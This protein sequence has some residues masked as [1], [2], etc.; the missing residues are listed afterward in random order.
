MTSATTTTGAAPLCFILM[1]FGKKTGADGTTIDF[2]RVYG[3][4]IAPAAA[5][6][7]LQPIRADEET[8]GGI[9]HKAMF[10]RLILCP[11][12][13]ADLTQANANVFYELGVRH[14]FRPFST[15]QLVAE[16]SRLPFDI[17]MQRTIPYK[18]DANGGPDAAAAERTRAAVAKF[19]V[20]AR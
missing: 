19:L 15:V 4:L 3:E 9:I 16:G 2:D 6:A 11:F 7:E 10:E 1:P 18:L 12:A 8:T 14:A 17:Q 5:A 20:E 13:I